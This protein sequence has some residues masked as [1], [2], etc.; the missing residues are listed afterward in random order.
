MLLG[1]NLPSGE[2]HMLSR[3]LASPCFDEKEFLAVW[4]IPG[5]VSPRRLSSNV[6]ATASPLV[7]RG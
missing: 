4:E 7:T 6:H 3:G 2:R 5:A 1:G